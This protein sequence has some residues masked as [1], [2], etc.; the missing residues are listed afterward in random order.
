[1][2]ENI[3]LS[4]ALL[5]PL[6]VMMSFWGGDQLMSKAFDACM[7]RAQK[8]GIRFGKV[9]RNK[10]QYDDERLETIWNHLLYGDRKPKT[11]A[12]RI[13]ALSDSK[14]A[15]YLCDKSCPP[16]AHCCGVDMDCRKCWMD[17]LKQPYEEA[18]EK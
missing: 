11:N 3:V 4:C 6:F 17:W 1:M 15:E 14:L 5:F 7:A 9:K 10:M 13:R 8:A 16:N 2:F 18:D 12:D